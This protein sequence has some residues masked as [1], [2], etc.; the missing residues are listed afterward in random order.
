MATIWGIPV[1]PHRHFSPAL[2]F[3]VHGAPVFILPARVI[4]CQKK[5]FYKSFNTEK[6][7][8]VIYR[9][10]ESL[11]CP[12][13]SWIVRY[14]NATSSALVQYLSQ[15]FTACIF[16]FGVGKPFSVMLMQEKNK[17]GTCLLLDSLLSC[18]M[19]ST[20]YLF[21]LQPFHPR[22]RKS[23]P[24]V[25]LLGQNRYEKYRPTEGQLW[26]WSAR[27]QI[28]FILEPVFSFLT[29]AYL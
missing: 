23:G 15:Y 20:H 13:P 7:Q 14:T 16:T 9:D 29:T 5:G 19:S 18:W 26:G 17:F 21:A 3:C 10:E 24:Q 27:R 4:K 11:L 25:P 22:Y 8:H 2:I 1:G 28:L 6:N 12:F